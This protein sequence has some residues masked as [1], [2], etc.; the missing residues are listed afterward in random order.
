VPESVVDT[1]IITL[2]GYQEESQRT[3][4]YLK[5]KSIDGLTYAV[6][7]LVGEAGELANKL[8]KHLRV[9]SPVDPEILADELGDVLWYA[10]SVA[11]ELNKTL[12]SVAFGNLIKLQERKAKKE[13]TN[14]F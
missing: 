3:A 13:L 1:S 7:G 2:D 10:S 11:N 8:K 9:G 4:V 14:H 6:L 5:Q 12:G